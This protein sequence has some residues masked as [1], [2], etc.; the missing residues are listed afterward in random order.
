MAAPPKPLS[1]DIHTSVKDGDMA[2][3]LEFLEEGGDVNVRCRYRTIPLHRAAAY[4]HSDIATLLLS[5]GADIEARDG[6]GHTPLFWASRGG[7]NDMV[8]LLLSK[9]AHIN[10]EDKKEVGSSLKHAGPNT[11]KHAGPSTL[12]HAGPS[13]MK[14]AG[15]STLSSCTVEEPWCSTR[16]AKRDTMD[17]DA[18]EPGED[19]EPNV[20]ESLRSE[21]RNMIESA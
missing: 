5:K 12:K 21:I 13:T 16:G 8:T 6:V 4:N 17:A 10:A 3:V 1:V 19:F 14:D 20:A 11:L 18:N 9:G 15:P 2:K 7:H